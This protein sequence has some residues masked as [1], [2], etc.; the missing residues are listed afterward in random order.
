MSL[1]FSTKFFWRFCRF[2]PNFGNTLATNCRFAPV[3]FSRQD[4]A[5]PLLSRCSITS[6][7]AYDGRGEV[8]V[9]IYIIECERSACGRLHHHLV[10]AVV[11]AEKFWRATLLALEDAVEVRHIIKSAVVANFSHRH[12]AC[13]WGKWST[14]C[15][16]R[17]GRSSLPPAEEWF[18]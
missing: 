10:L 16:G 15:S 7:A 14:P 2:P 6:A 8:C 3:G 18:R 1:P 17:W 12:C 9:D 4:A 11:F 13:E 5:S